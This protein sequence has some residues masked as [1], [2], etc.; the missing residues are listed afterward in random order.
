MNLF[1]ELDRLTT[2]EQK[3]AFVL[4]CLHIWEREREPEAAFA[5]A[6]LIHWSSP[7]ELDISAFNER[8]LEMDAKCFEALAFERFKDLAGSGSSAAARWVA[9]YYSGGIHPVEKSF[10]QARHWLARAAELGDK[11]A[12]KEIAFYQD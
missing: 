1:D 9:V 12:A 3:R 5:L 8:H 11:S 4:K 7:A 2:V 6:S 10:A